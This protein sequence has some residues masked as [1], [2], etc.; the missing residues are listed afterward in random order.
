MIFSDAGGDAAFRAWL[1]PI[2]ACAET[3]R[4]DAN[5]RTVPDWPT[6]I[7]TATVNYAALWCGDVPL[8]A[9]GSVSISVAA[10]L[11]RIART[12]VRFVDWRL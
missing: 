6:I 5:S 12:P 3:A 9:N 1:R 11:E 2:A 10:E 7:N 4:T 8:V